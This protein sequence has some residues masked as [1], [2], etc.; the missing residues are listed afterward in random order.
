M[1]GLAKFRAVPSWFVVLPDCEAAGLVSPVLQDHARQAIKHPSGR[2]WVLGRW[3]EG[4]VAIGEA[5]RTMLALIGQ[6]ATR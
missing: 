3:P 4:T 5:G 6:H 2:P 1:T